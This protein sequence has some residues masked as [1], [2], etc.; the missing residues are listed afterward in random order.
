LGVGSHYTLGDALI[1]NAFESLGKVYD[2]PV[3]LA[4]DLSVINVTPEQI[5]IRQAKTS[6]LA[7]VPNA[8]ILEGVDMNPGEPSESQTPDWLV[9]TRIQK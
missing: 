7:T 2:G 9:K 6:M 3:L 8:P 5:V 1:D 4:H